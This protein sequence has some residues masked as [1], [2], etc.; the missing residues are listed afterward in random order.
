MVEHFAS[1]SQSIICRLF[2]STISEC[3]FFGLETSNLACL[4]LGEWIRSAQRLL[5]LCLRQDILKE[6][7]QVRKTI[8]QCVAFS[9]IFSV[10]A[11]GGCSLDPEVSKLKEAA[12]VTEENT[13][14][15]C[16]D[17]LD[18]DGDTLVDCDDPG[19]QAKGSGDVKLPG[20]T[21]CPG[22][23]TNGVWKASENTIYTCNDGIDNDGNGYADCQ[24]NSCKTLSVCCVKT[25][26]ENTEEACSDGIDNDC[27]G[28][29]DC[30]DNNCKKLSVCCVATGD[31]NTVETC[32]DGIDND[33][34]GYT[35]C[36]DYSCK[37]GSS[38]DSQATEEAIAFCAAGGT[39]GEEQPE[40]TESACSDGVDN[41]LNGLIDCADPDCASFEYCTSVADIKEP[42]TRPD[43]FDSLSA[44]QKKAIYSEENKYCTD[45][46]DN[47]H[48]GRE[49]CHE[50]QCHVLSVK[51]KE[52]LESNPDGELK[53]Y[54]FTCQD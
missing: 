35:D 23:V 22:V 9:V 5:T 21:V 16:T 18:N 15:L 50:Y 53:G 54:A 32:D 37:G 6:V 43:N 49:D 27:N 34:D 46:L 24:D 12:N 48:N 33:C 3:H 28:Y 10:C 14:I 7:K 47:D 17:G 20:D 25:G 39:V 52:Y 1:Q 40:N 26:S 45:G 31:E 51:W 4:Y 19:C 2:S 13:I 41:N 44:K 36:A 11:L 30:A 38:K 42:P 8:A 29:T